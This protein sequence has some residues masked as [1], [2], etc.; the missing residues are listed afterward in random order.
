MRR[1]GAARDHGTAPV[2]VR[3]DECG[4]P[5]PCVRPYNSCRLCCCAVYDQAGR[6]LYDFATSA[7]WGGDSLHGHRA[8]RDPV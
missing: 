6:R 8:L 2:E 1:A 3:C 5:V 4:A 7:N